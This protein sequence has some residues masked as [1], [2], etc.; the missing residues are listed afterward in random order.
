MFIT[1]Q[2]YH[3]SKKESLN[4]LRT[5]ILPINAM[6][7]NENYIYGLIVVFDFLSGAYI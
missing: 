2:F 4:P 3:G 1:L 5:Q 6:D 7:G